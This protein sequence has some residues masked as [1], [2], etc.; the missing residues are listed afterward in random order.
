M[1]EVA[2]TAAKNLNNSKVNLEFEFVPFYEDCGVCSAPYHIFNEPNKAKNYV[3][4]I[5]SQ[6]GGDKENVKYA[7][8]K[9][10]MNHNFDN[11]TILF[12]ITDQGFHGN[13]QTSGSAILEHQE[14]NKLGYPN[15][16][17]SIFS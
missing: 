7:L 5:C 8:A 2:I 14:L 9:Y 10:H 12:L 15:D 1:G 6:G 13:T 16:I 4:G 3:E 17:Y 11:P